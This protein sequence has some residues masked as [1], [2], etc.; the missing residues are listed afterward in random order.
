MGGLAR[1]IEQAGS[2]KQSTVVKTTTVT[3]TTDGQPNKSKPS[4]S[5]KTANM[6]STANTDEAGASLVGELPPVVVYGEKELL[7]RCKEVYTRARRLE[8]IANVTWQ[9]EFT[10]MAN[11]P[12][13]T[14]ETPLPPELGITEYFPATL[15]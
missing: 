8:E 6:A 14:L 2:A 4:A 1:R 12:D 9:L 15:A 7:K 10:T 3:S 11:G 5:V 13:F